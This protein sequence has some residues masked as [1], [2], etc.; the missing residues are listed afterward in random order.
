MVWLQVSLP[1]YA[2]VQDTSHETMVNQDIVQHM[3]W[4]SWLCWMKQGPLVTWPVLKRC[5]CDHKAIESTEL[6]KLH[7]ILTPFLLPK[8]ANGALPSN[9]VTPHSSA[10]VTHYEQHVTLWNFS[11]AVLQSL[12]ELPCLLLITYFIGWCIC[13]NDRYMTS[14]TL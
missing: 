9:C 11:H 2:S 6:Q 3:P 12:V 1:V 10:E 5:V 14:L 4:F 8:P 13:S 7:S